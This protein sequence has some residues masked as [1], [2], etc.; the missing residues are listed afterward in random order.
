[1]PGS[2][3][4]LESCVVCH[5]AAAQ[6]GGTGQLH[7]L[8]INSDPNYYTFPTATQYYSGFGS[9]QLAPFNTYASTWNG[10]L[11][12]YTDGNGATQT[13]PAVG[14]DVDIACGQCHTGNDGNTNTYGI[15]PVGTAAPSFTRAQLASY[16]KGIHNS[17]QTV[18]ATP[19]LSLGGST[20][21]ASGAPYSVTISE[22]VANASICYTID[23]TTPVYLDAGIAT[24]AE[25]VI[26]SCSNGTLATT[27]V[28]IAISKNTTL[29]ALAAGANTQGQPLTPS[30]IISATYSLQAAAPVLV[31]GQFSAPQ[32]LPLTGATGYCTAPAGTNCTTM[33]PVVGPLTISVPT[34]V[35]AVNAPANF[36]ASAIT[37]ATFNVTLSAPTFAPPAGSISKGTTVVITGP[38][39]STIHYTTNG[40]NPTASSAA[41][42]AGSGTASVV[43]AASEYVR[44]I[45]V[46]TSGT[47]TVQSAIAT[48][49][50]AAH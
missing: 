32:T 48:A 2:T 44:A 20:Y 4:A 28:T 1:M 13:Y 29:Q 36:V 33:L 24:F 34:T 14:L 35:R 45:A 50:Y 3:N 12:T 25:N 37:T 17:T 38:A 19:T 15:V 27:G 11:E 8:R 10:S 22:A 9:G 21:P 46:Y 5:M 6:T 18:A 42:T 7:F 23:G 43:V 49:T 47:Q 40:S 39:G 26:P 30:A 16:A 31:G 41:G